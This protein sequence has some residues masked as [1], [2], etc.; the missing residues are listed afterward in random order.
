[1]IIVVVSKAKITYTNNFIA[2]VEQ[3]YENKK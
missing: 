1:M 3:Q 2:V